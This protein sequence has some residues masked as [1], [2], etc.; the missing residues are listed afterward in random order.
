MV[1]ALLLFLD[2]SDLLKKLRAAGLFYKA[3]K[4]FLLKSP[5]YA[6]DKGEHRHEHSADT[7]Q[8]AGRY[9]LLAL[10]DAFDHLLCND[11]GILHREGLFEFHAVGCDLEEV[12]V[13]SN[14]IQAGQL[15]IPG[16]FEA[17]TLLEALKA[18]LGGR[19]QRIAGH[20]HCAYRGNGVGKMTVT[21]VKMMQV[22]YIGVCRSE[23]VSVEDSLESAPILVVIE[24]V[25]GETCVVVIDI[26]VLNTKR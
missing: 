19:V 25:V 18:E 15:H 7:E 21:A 6:A 24:L 1:L 23:R 14:R 20:C 16:H 22:F 5:I 17:Y 9:L 10:F 8:E 26:C 2:L 12:R 3:F 11:A 4:L 13:G